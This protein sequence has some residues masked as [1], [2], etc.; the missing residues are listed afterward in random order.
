MSKNE[1]M[2]DWKDVANSYFEKALSLSIIIMLFAVMT[3]PKFEIKVKKREA[4]QVEA[5]DIPPEIREKIKPP[6]A[7]KIELEIIIDDEEMEGEDEELEEVGT[8][9]VTTLDAQEIVAPTRNEGQTPKFVAYEDPPQVVSSVIPEYPEFAKKSGL[10]GDVWLD[11]EVLEDGSVG[12]IE[13]IES[14]QPGPGGLD[15]S[16][17]TAVKQWKFQPAK[18]NGQS[19]ACWVKFPVSFVF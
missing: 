17:V 14:L 16:A 12:A 18:S 15:E 19:V 10:Q 5:I 13:I 11:V 7:A 4:R 3:T 6:E 8:I 9:E 2:Q 1:R